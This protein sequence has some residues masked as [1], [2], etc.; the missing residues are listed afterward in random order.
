ME[1]ATQDLVNSF[2]SWSIT[3]VPN[4]GLRLIVV[5]LLLFIGRWVARLFGQWVKRILLRREVDK[6]VVSFFEKLTT[7]GIMAIIVIMALNLIGFPTTSLIAVLGAFALAIGLALQDT[8]SNFA[9]GIL[10]IVLRPY[11]IHDLVEL[12]GEQGHVE[13]IRFFHTVL[14]TGD[15]MLLFIPNSD[16]MDNNIINYS[17]MDW[18]RLDLT[19]GI[20]Y[21]D[22][23]LKAKKILQAI[24]KAD[25]RIAADPAPTVAVREL[26]DSS[27]NLAVRPYVKEADMVQV[28]FDLTEQVKLRFDAEGISIPFPQ[29]D[30][31][32]FQA[33]PPYLS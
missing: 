23:L 32:L 4:L 17:Q 25:N 19:F 16:V 30:V 8:L 2:T 3:N 33:T 14:R 5:I 21:G 29:R 31:H 7:Y 11:R 12:S 24:V 22:D 13:E 20:D 1:S 28:K 9:A 6:A 15:N 10:L 18:I 27:V 26:G